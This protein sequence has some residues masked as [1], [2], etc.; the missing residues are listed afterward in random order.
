VGAVWWLLL[1]VPLLLS[2][3]LWS[4][5]AVATESSA[6][7]AD[8]YVSVGA[9]RSQL[10]PDT[11]DSLYR[12]DQRGDW[13]YRL[14]AG[15]DINHHW[16]LE[17]Y[18][19]DLGEA[20]LAPKGRL[21]YRAYGASL[22]G[23]YWLL[24][25]ERLPW[26][27][28][29]TARGGIGSLSN[30]AQDLA[31]E[32]QSALQLTTALGLELYLPDNFS[33]ALQVDAYDADATLLSLNLTKRFGSQQSLVYAIPQDDPLVMFSDLP[34]TGAGIRLARIEPL[35]VD[36]DGDDVLDDVDRC[37][38]TPFAGAVTVDEYG[39]A[40]FQGVMEQLQFEPASAR[41]TASSLNELRAL[42]AEIGV[43]MQNF[44]KLRLQVRVHTDS[45]GSDNY[46]RRL[47]QQRAESVVSE[48][49]RLQ[50]DRSRLSALG[51]GERQPLA[52][53]RTPEGRQKNRRV[54]FVLTGISN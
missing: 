32:Q 38:S 22:V 40:R 33:A 3:T 6:L 49:L 50:I 35:V 48:L 25:G 51:L 1:L 18:Y 37:L 53:N 27:L 31:F 21:G 28:A 10:E 34:P 12:I 13:G 26:S 19:S 42:A 16:S 14:A 24:G 52:S 9:G 39:C 2:T 4:T 7:K 36:S 5:K 17:G 11:S 30:Q 41:L 15:W 54:E 45:Q 47:S 46:N 23:S 20:R 29:L 44:A 43:Q 8:W